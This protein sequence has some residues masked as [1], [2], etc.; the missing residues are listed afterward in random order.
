MQAMVEVTYHELFP[1]TEPTLSNLM[2]EIRDVFNGGRINGFK[3]KQ[4]PNS[5]STVDLE[6]GC[7]PVGQLCV[8]KI[9]AKVIIDDIVNAKLYNDAL[10]AEYAGII[11]NLPTFPRMF[12]GKKKIWVELQVWHE[13]KI[14]TYHRA[15]I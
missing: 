4:L 9:V 7:G 10:A 15:W 5:L 1:L 3:G 14:L 6:A 8:M 2:A 13:E 11:R 12:V